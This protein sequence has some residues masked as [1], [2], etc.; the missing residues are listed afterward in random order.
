MSFKSKSTLPQ[1]VP[2]VVGWML[3]LI[4]FNLFYEFGRELGPSF[5]TW[6][7]FP[8]AYRRG[9]YDVIPAPPLPGWAIP[10]NIAFGVVST[11]IIGFDV[12][13]RARGLH[14]RWMGQQR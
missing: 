11:T 14:G 13:L 8:F 9:W 3:L 4:V 7:G 6:Y 1:V 10:A 12:H 2:V 5:E